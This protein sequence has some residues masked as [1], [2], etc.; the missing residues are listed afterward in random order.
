KCS[1]NMDFIKLILYF[2]KQSTKI[3]FVLSVISGF[4]IF[5]N[6]KYIK[7]FGFERIDVYKPYISLVFLSS[8]SILLANIVIYIANCI[9]RKMKRINL[10]KKKIKQLDNLDDFEKAVLREF[11]IEGKNSL[12]MPINDEVIAGLLSKNVLIYNSQFGNRSMAI[13]LD[14][15]LS[16]NPIIEEKITNEKIDFPEEINQETKDFLLNNRPDWVD[17]I[18]CEKIIMK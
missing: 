4:I 3:F 2:F 18:N 11:Y 9:S 10:D 6:D 12:K 8:L 1:N 7:V 13:G 5:S 14:F 16:I 17:R 15:P